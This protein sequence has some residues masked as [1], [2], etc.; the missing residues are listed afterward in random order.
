MGNALKILVIHKEGNLHT[1]IL[2][3]EA[4]Q[5]Q[6]LGDVLLTMN[7]LAVSELNITDPLEMVLYVGKT[8]SQHFVRGCDGISL[9]V[10]RNE[11]NHLKGFVGLKLE[12]EIAEWHQLC[13]VSPYKGVRDQ[14]SMVFTQHK[15]L[16][17][18]PE[19]SWKIMPNHSNLVETMQ[20]NTNV[21][22]VV[23]IS[24][25]RNNQITAELADAEQT[26]NLPNTRNAVFECER[27]SVQ[28]HGWAH[29]AMG[30][31]SAL[32][33]H[34]HTL[35]EEC[36]VGAAKKKELLEKQKEINIRL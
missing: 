16:S 25:T 30:V 7:N 28:H 1:I 2:D 33:N 5:M 14:P 36:N 12:E 24:R 15:S 17:K 35:E 9:E 20:I 29:A 34:F 13:I 10:P 21:L 18:I 6:S 23:V 11:I 3:A 26:G 27:W 19:N 32:V 8:C 4:S 22:T 31:W